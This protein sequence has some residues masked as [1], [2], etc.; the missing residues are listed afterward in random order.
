MHNLGD[1]INPVQPSSSDHDA[2]TREDSSPDAEERRRQARQEILERGRMMEERRRKATEGQQRAKSQSFDDLVD[3]EGRLRKD[4]ESE[5]A[6][7]ATATET[8][9]GD[10]HLRKRK[11]EDGAA[12]GSRLANPFDDEIMLLDLRSQKSEETPP[13]PPRPSS[14]TETPPPVPPK[15]PH[16]EISR[17]ILPPISIPASSTPP[18]LPESLVDL[19]PN[20]VTPTTS[21]FSTSHAD[22]LSLDQVGPHSHALTPSFIESPSHSRSS[23]PSIIASPPTA[24]IPQQQSYFSVNEW[25]ENAS[26]SFHTPPRAQ[27]P[28]IVLPEAGTPNAM[29]STPRSDREAAREDESHTVSEDDTR[30]GFE[31]DSEMDIISQVS[32]DGQMT[33][34]SWTEVGSTFS[35][36]E[37]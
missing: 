37:R 29:N 17:P 28:P 24:S 5:I 10:V 16:D 15:I 18:H 20:Q 33:P 4:Q 30:Y 12:L 35:D 7:T 1:D 27:T 25:A 9:V 14:Q 13:V 2:S 19:T 31:S 11:A 22:L 6:T 36:D 26:A 23:T 34:V 32:G 21:T 3:Q 8:I